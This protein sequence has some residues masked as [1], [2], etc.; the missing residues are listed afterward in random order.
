MLLNTKRREGETVPKPIGKIIDLQTMRL[1]VKKQKAKENFLS[2]FAH[3]RG[4]CLNTKNSIK[5]LSSGIA[6]FGKLKGSRSAS[7]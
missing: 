7:F 6:C 1:W 5:L 3:L 2:P 4:E